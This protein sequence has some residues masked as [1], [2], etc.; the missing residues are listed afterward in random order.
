YVLAGIYSIGRSLLLVRVVQAVVGAGGCALL[1]YGAA[2][3]FGRRAGL[4]AGLALAVYAPAIFAG[5]LVQKSVLDLF[6]VCVVLALVSALAADPQR[7]WLWAA[8]GAALGAL[9]LT[10][11]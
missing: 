4:A 3:W 2:R 9:S 1:S 8:I 10:R 11:E 7:P 6:F 5:A